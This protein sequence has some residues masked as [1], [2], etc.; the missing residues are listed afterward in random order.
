ML[1][2]RM[3]CISFSFLCQSFV[4]LYLFLVLDSSELC[5]M[6][7]RP[8]IMTNA[9]IIRALNCSPN[10]V[11]EGVIRSSQNETSFTGTNSSCFVLMYNSD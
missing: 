9:E 11:V 10:R 5:L 1:A 6:I 3:T 7:S 8:N 4:V 2:L